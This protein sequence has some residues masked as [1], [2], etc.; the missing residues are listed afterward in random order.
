MADYSAYLKLQEQAA[1]SHQGDLGG[2]TL[3]NAYYGRALCL[4]KLGQKAQALR[5]LNQCIRLGPVDEQMSE[6]DA[7]L[8]PRAKVAKMLLKQ[9]YPE[10]GGAEEDRDAIV[11]AAKRAAEAKRAA[12]QQQTSS[13]DEPVYEGKVWRVP[14]TALEPALA[15]VAAAGK[16]P[17]LLDATDT[18]VTDMYFMYS[19]ATVV[20]AKK[21]VTDV[22]MAGTTVEAAREGLRTQLVHA[23]RWG[24]LL[25]VRMANSAADFC[26]SYCSPDAFPVDLFD[27]TKLP[28]GRDAARDPLW[29]PVLRP[30]DTGG[31]PAPLPVPPQFS[32]VVTSTFKPDNYEKLLQ[33][34]L[35]LQHLQP[36]EVFVPSEAARALALAGEGATNSGPLSGIIA[37]WGGAWNSS[38]AR[39][40]GDA[41]KA[42]Q[43]QGD[44]MSLFLSN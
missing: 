30:A 38:A 17:L 37:D 44:R 9:A 10:L 42:G 5:D 18:R 21:V 36:V 1:K 22:R 31:G 14:I 25:V 34:A 12:S 28:A 32:V 26:G 33:G 13:E 16:T 20:E 24:H 27:A 4:A 23:M 43:L 11:A 7:S 2:P 39:T 3:A 35:P 41:P 6:R 40:R 29:L 15:K 19:E 8:V